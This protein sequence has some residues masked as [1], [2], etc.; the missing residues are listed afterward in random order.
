[1]LCKDVFSC[2]GVTMFVLMYSYFTT[3]MSVELTA[4]LMLSTSS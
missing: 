2:S 3:M 4:A 1:M